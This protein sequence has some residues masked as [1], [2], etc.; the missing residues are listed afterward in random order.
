MDALLR[1]NSR[2]DM[3]PLVFGLLTVE[4]TTV[5]QSRKAESPHSLLR[6]I[7]H[8]TWILIHLRIS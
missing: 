8:R 5:V 6:Q 7:D 2:L 1:C 3:L 4:C